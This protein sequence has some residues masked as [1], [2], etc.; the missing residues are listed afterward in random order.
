MDHPALRFLSS[1]FS[2]FDPLDSLMTFRPTTNGPRSQA[3]FDLLVSPVPQSGTSK[4]VFASNR[5]GVMQIY[6]MNADGSNVVRFTNSGGNDDFPRWSPNGA[7][8]LFQSDRD[9]PDTG[10]MD[11][12]VMNS[13]GSGV[14]RLTT[15][16]NDDSFA[17]WSSDGSKIVFQSMRNG[18]NYQVYSMNADGSNQVNLTNTS[19][20]DGEPS[21]SP[22]GTKIAL[23]SDRD[24]AGFD[25]VYVMNSNGSNQHRITFSS[26]TIDD[27]QPMW[28]RDGSRITFVSTRDSTTETWQETDDD[29]NYITKSKVHINK[30]VYVMNADGSGQLR[31]TND[32]ANDDAPSW[33]P[34]GS[35]IVFRSDRERDCCDPSAQV[36]TMNTDGSGLT[37]ISSSGNGD[38]SASWTSESNNQSP[39]ANAGGAYNGIISQNVPFA[40]NGSIDPDGSIVSYSWNFGDGGTASGVAPTHAYPTIGTYTVTLTVTDNLGAQ[41]SAS[42]SVVITSSSSDQY[43][44]NFLQ[45]GLGRAPNSDEGN[46]WTD[47]M[48]AAYMQGQPSMFMTMT[49]FGMTVFESADYANRGRS[50]RD[51]VND[52]YRTYLMRD[53]EYC[54]PN[55]PYCGSNYWT[56]QASPQHMGREQVRNAFEG[57]GEFHNIVS[58]LT[59][60]GSPSSAA[61]SLATAQVDLFNQSG[62]QVEA[63]DCEFSVPLLSLPGRAGLDLG[64]SL[65]Y[66]SLVWTRSGPY[67]Y[68]DQDYESVS[69]GFTI[70]FPTVQW[71]KFDAQTS[72]NVYVFTAA[73]HHVELRQV[74]SSNFYE[75]SDSSYLQLTD[76]GGTLSVRSTDGTEID[77]TNTASGWRAIQIE[78]RNGNI[79][80]ITNDWRGDI[81]KIIDT[82][83]R[84]IDF[85][86]DGNAQLL[87]ITQ[88][89]ANEPQHPWATF[90]WGVS[91]Q[92]QLPSGSEAVGTFSGDSF[93][94]LAQVNLP[95]SSHY[96]FDYNAAAQVSVIHR[97]TSDNVQRSQMVYNYG[98]GDDST[99]LTNSRV[100]A[101]SWTSTADLP[102][103]YVETQYNLEG[104][105]HTATVVGDPSGTVYKESYGTGWQ[106]GLVTATETWG[107]KDPEHTVGI[108]RWTST[109]WIQDDPN[110]NAIYRTN[111]RVTATD[112]FDN[113]NHSHTTIGYQT[114]TLPFSN[115]SCSLPNDVYEYDGTTILRRNHTDYNLDTNYLNQRIIG[116]P[117]AK[118]LYEGPSTLMAKMTYLYDWN[119]EYLQGLPATPTQHDGSYSTDIVPDRVRANLVKL[120][121][122]DV[123]YPT[124]S[125]KV[126]ESKSAYDITGNVIFTCD[127]LD[128][129]TTIT[130]ADQFAAN[131][132][133]LDTP[134][135]FSTFAYPTTINDA[136]NNSS[137]VRYRYD[138]GAKT[139]VQGPPPQ[140][141]T[142]G[143]EQ[144][145]IYDSAT[146]IQRVTTTY[147]GAYTQYL[148]GPA[149]VVT[150][151]SINS[152]A[153]EAYTNSTFDG[154]GRSIGVATNNTGSSGGYKARMT[155]YDIMGRVMKQSNPT[156]IT[157]SWVSAGDDAAG[158][159]STEQTYDWKGRP[160][161]TIN[162]DSTIKYASYDGCGC[163]G[164]EVVTLTD[165]G[166]LVNGVL[167][168]RQ[169]RIYSD[170]LGRQWRA[171]VLNWDST[172]HSTSVSVYSGRDQVTRVKQYAGQAPAEASS[173]NADASCPTG[174]CQETV[175]AYDGYGRLQTKHVP[176]QQID[177]N[178]S[179]STNHTAWSYN[180][181]D[182]IGSMTDARGVT[183]TFGYNGR[184]LMT[185]ITY[186]QSLPSGVAPIGNVSVGYDAA[187]NRTSMSDGTGLMSYN[188]DPLSRLSS[189][190]KTF[191]GLSGSFTLG[192]EYNL[193]NQVRSVTDQ[194]SGTSF[195]TVYDNIGRVT[196]VSGVGYGGVV[197]PFASQM[198]YRASGALKSLT[199]GN[200]TT[201]NL[202][203][204]VRGSVTSY[205][206]A[207][208]GSTYQYYADGRVKF[209]HDQSYNPVPIKDRAYQYDYAGRIAEAYSGAEARDFVNNTNS[210]TA[211]G[212]FR[213]TYTYDAW[214]NQ[215]NESGR[216]WSRPELSYASYNSA[217]RNTTWN[218]DVEGNVLSR[219]DGTSVFQA[220]Q[221]GYDGASHR[222]SSNQNSSYFS[223]EGGGLISQAASKSQGY[224]GDGNLLRDE[225]NLNISVNG[226][227]RTSINDTTYNLRSSVLGGAVISEYNDQGNWQRTY[228]YA[229]SQR[230]G[231]QG[232]GENGAA[233]STW[234]HVDP[235]TGDEIITTSAGTMFGQTVLDS[236]G[237]DVGQNDPFPPDGS[238]DPNGIAISEVSDK[239][240]AGLLPIEDGGQRCVLDGI[241]M[242]CGFVRKESATHCPDNDCGPRMDKN[243]KLTELFKTY[244]DGHGGFLPHGTKYLGD[245]IY[246]TMDEEFHMLDETQNTVPDTSEFER[247]IKALD[248]KCT[249][250][251]K[252][253]ITQTATAKNPAEFTDALTGFDMVKR[254]GGFIYG[255]TIMKLYGLAGGTVNGRI[256]ENTAQVELPTPGQFRSFG[257]VNQRAARDFAAMQ[258]VTNFWTT[259]HEILHLAGKNVYDD[260]AYAN[261]VAAMKGVNA[262]DYTGMKYHDALL[263]ASKYWNQAL[264]DACKPQGASR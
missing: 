35:K 152:V 83:G 43:A 109:S 93:P 55:D 263:K 237:V 58:T 14:T 187:G 234:R 159:L 2:Q 242:N 210:G 240:S 203:Y 107:K 23:A 76:N 132:G 171:E 73:G 228:V 82:L 256:S 88:D 180:P 168:A 182:T 183:S 238:G 131:G 160:L 64:L 165:E 175:M 176:A 164:G 161:E 221:Y 52:L 173:T 63:R 49:E 79:I 68:F 41:G 30:E 229:G 97:T 202:G 10:Y 121:R 98:A 4:I 179:S 134:R 53:P 142:T 85:H 72:R 167:Q 17:S 89:W 184:H 147:T 45:K 162:Q 219:N 46:Y 144:T 33:S 103:A 213:Q 166:T 110:P 51:Y 62:N 117:K 78:D 56:N 22:D 262:P 95:D 128:H 69:P 101:D 188:Y 258:Q 12:Y 15:D 253:L 115:A 197:T 42:T 13:N 54:D 116:L 233:F 39:V 3:L 75:A 47:I 158:W 118:L 67:I 177:P 155:E 100:S 169:Q 6:V 77:Y 48:R 141:Q 181:D 135:S 200:N 138:F 260:F 87:S 59:A 111:P 215:L 230:V 130:Y 104:S 196:S 148:Y 252:N 36:W 5:E 212:P 21:W 254:Q 28:S 16:V 124:D 129:Q 9:H 119:G 19:S 189:E 194:R 86:Y 122:W 246:M 241:E 61:S 207:M 174:S 91:P 235:V 248:S 255:D 99:R 71:R 37:N 108:Q 149:N 84:E 92:M 208:V 222:V 185:S 150:L 112:V 198:L 20:S 70:G 156:E 225:H 126:T 24:H 127:A 231:Q 123:N 224:D 18:V 251:I 27:T 96:N 226:S 140:N 223:T 247:R 249:T 206:D 151:S 205:S 204:N 38:Y 139:L 211:D 239:T 259:L 257:P 250:F 154:L 157:G 25:S 199:Y 125:T 217:N 106:K 192:Y 232:K 216:F 11:V 220:A 236:Q 143:L 80:S 66:S 120:Q 32:L 264:L 44:V 146:R 65:S 195:S 40:G 172:V 163:A 8:I 105:I 29:G 137:Y 218:Y 193:A 50:D 94:V 190:T 7:K 243:G 1:H 31:L 170:V 57:S 74:G 214:D 244:P 153:N 133:A 113:S 261:T 227:L 178:N 186:P 136:D 201:L 209:A 245:G 114:F 60:S 191:N 34:D 90:G 102:A 26:D 81:Q 145:F